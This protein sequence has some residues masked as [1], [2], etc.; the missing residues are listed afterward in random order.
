VKDNID[1]S[2]RR[3]DNVSVAY[4]SLNK[5]YSV[6]YGRLQPWGSAFPV[7]LRLKVIK[8][9][10]RPASRLQQIDNMG[11]NEPSASGNQRPVFMR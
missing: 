4:V 8:N 6:L 1:A 9:P 11:A 7:R 3:L 10:N 5:F 2:E